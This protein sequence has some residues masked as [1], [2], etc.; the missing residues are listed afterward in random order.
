[1]IKVML[2][3]RGIVGF[4]FAMSVVF[5]FL[6]VLFVHIVAEGVISKVES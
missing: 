5:I 3:I 2:F 4:C 6:I 1:M